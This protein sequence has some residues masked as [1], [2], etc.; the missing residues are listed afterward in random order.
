MAADVALRFLALPCRGRFNSL[1]QRIQLSLAPSLSLSLALAARCD[2]TLSAAPKSMLH[3]NKTAKKC[4]RNL[5]LL[6]VQPSKCIGRRAGRQ[7]GVAGVVQAVYALAVQSCACCLLLTMQQ[8]QNQQ[9]Q[10]QQQLQL[11]QQQL[12]QQ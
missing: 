1:A 10:Q 4:A 12:Q 11:Q 6:W 8:Q 2:W 7:V 3:E 9:Q 5:R